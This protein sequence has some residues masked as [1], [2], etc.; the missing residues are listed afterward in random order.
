M[1]VGSRRKVLSGTAHKTSGGLRAS[2][3]VRTKSG[4]IASRKKIEA[5]K[6]NPHLSAWSRAFKMMRDAYIREG[7]ST[8]GFTPLR[9]GTM[10]YNDVRHAYDIQMEGRARR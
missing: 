5:F 7:R 3:L 1:T 4:R 2:N 10:E 8:R 6:R 9:K